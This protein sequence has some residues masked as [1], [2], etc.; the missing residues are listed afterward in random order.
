MNERN[1]SHSS[2]FLIELIFVIFFFSLASMLCV[3]VF[4]KAHLISKQAKEE[5]LGSNL[6]SS[7][8]EV[9][10]DTETSFDELFPEAKK[11]KDGWQIPYDKNGEQTS[12]KHASYYLNVISKADK[13]LN[14]YTLVFEDTS[15]VSIYQLDLKI[16]IP[17]TA[18]AKK[19]EPDS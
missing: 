17:R 11:T 7:V 9:L 10:S 18:T 19:E 15:G 4:V 5:S 16:T 13:T 1:S 3:Q 14:Q 8:A 12:L 2:L 6:V